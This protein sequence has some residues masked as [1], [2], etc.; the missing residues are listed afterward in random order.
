MG[1]NELQALAVQI[2]AEIVSNSDIQKSLKNFEVK[3]QK[4]DG[5]VQKT[6]DYPVYF[7]N[8]AK[9]KLPEEGASVSLWATNLSQSINPG[10]VIILTPLV[11]A[12]FTFLRNRKKEP[13]TP[14][15]IAFGLLISALSVLVMIAAVNM[16]ANGTEKVSVWWLS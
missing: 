13:S 8:V 6:V 4:V 10:W 11:V 16:G 9:D 3:I 5:E 2:E 15:K 7:R 12:F 14:T 1:A